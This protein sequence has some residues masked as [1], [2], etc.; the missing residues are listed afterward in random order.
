MHQ[1]I[2]KLQQERP[3]IT[4]GAWGTQLQAHGLPLDACPDSWNLSHP[5]VV[6][7]VARSY[8]AAGSRVILT[9]TFGANRLALARHGLA[10]KAAAINRTGAAISRSAAGTAVHVIASMGPT[11]KLLAMGEV[12]EAEVRSC[13]QEQA[14]ALAAGGA[15]GIVVETMS[16]LTEARLA[17]E[18]ARETGLPVIACMTFGAG[19]A[20]DRTLMGITPEQAAEALAAAGA[21]AIGANCGNGAAELLPVCRRLRAAT[22]LPIWIK[23]NAG[24]PELTGGSVPTVTY[25]TTPEEFAQAAAA[26]VEAGAD[27][28]GGCCGTGPVFIQA[29]VRTLGKETPS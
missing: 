27:F 5:D 2:E 3:V 26:L 19:K 28:I 15:E 16:D 6:E 24:L 18:A 4:D 9:N 25:R 17:V 20:G 29:L 10:E 12:P 14:H 8:V 21:D 7:A 1:L 22:N 23:P 13:F 11:G